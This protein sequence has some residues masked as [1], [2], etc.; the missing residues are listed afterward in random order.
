MYWTNGTTDDGGYDVQIAQDELGVADFSAEMS[1]N[2]FDASV[3]E[4]KANE[5]DHSDSDHSD[6]DSSDDLD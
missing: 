5:S 4:I 6:S 2:D 1:D 3:L